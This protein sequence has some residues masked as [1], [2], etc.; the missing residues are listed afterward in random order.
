MS[1]CCA[2]AVNIPHPSRP[3]LA[4]V[5]T[6]PS[7]PET[8]RGSKPSAISHCPSASYRSLR[9]L[10]EPA[11][12]C[13]YEICL[14]LGPAGRLNEPGVAAAAPKQWSVASAL[15]YGACVQRTEC[16][17]DRGVVPST[18]S[19]CHSVS[20]RNQAAGKRPRGH[21]RTP[22]WM[23]ARYQPDASQMPSTTA[24]KPLPPTWLCSC[25]CG[26]GQDSAAPVRPESA[27]A[28]CGCRPLAAVVQKAQRRQPTA[29]RRAQKKSESTPP[30][31]DPP[32]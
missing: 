23:P 2:A 22:L 31:G 3:G 6:T 16:P 10:K 25:D 29:P 17:I 7:R 9:A 30:R 27:T 19:L 24:H 13:G 14:L 4:H 5:A 32:I 8:G 20:W 21:H 18:L 28:L 26:R 1:M 15:N 12:G 11:I